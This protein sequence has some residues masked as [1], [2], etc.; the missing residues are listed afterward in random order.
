[1]LWNQ[2]TL[3]I[4]FHNSGNLRYM[5]EHAAAARSGARLAL[6]RYQMLCQLLAAGTCRSAWTTG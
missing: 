5:R 4:L 6:N 1:V 3:L 2:S